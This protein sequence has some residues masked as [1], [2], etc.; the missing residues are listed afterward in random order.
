MRTWTVVSAVI[1]LLAVTSCGGD[2]AS[3]EAALATT[4]QATPSGRLET[5]FALAPFTAVDL[6]G[7]DVSP[8]T[9]RGRVV[10][11]NVWA[12]WCAPCRREIPALVALQDKYRDRVLVIGLLQ[13]NVTD[14]FARQFAASVKVNYPIVRSTFEVESQFPPVLALPATF[15]VDKTGRLVAAFAGEVD[16]AALEQE[17]KTELAR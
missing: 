16:I 10:V 1:L 6:D 15:I 11:I 2:G 9:W 17:V 8:A 12:T 7:R 3:P 13:D 5:P 4:A 14:A